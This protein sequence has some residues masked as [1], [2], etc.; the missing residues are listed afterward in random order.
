MTSIYD[1]SFSNVQKVCSFLIL[2]YKI[3]LI[4]IYV[5]FIHLHVST[6]IMYFDQ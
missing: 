3:T 4:Y 6:C 1:F 2:I 5:T